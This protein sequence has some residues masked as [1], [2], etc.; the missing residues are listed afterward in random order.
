MTAQIKGFSEN[1]SRIST[2]ELLQQI[3]AALDRGETE[4]EVT[5]SGHHI[6]GGPF[7]SEDGT[8]LKFEVKN[9][10][11]RVGGFGLAGTTI[12]VDGPTPADAGWLN[13]GAELIIK[14]DSGDTTAHCAASGKIYVAGR[15]GTR[16]GSLMKHDPAF[17]APELWV[18]K[19]AGSFSFEFMGGGTAVICGIDCDDYP[20]LLGDRSRMGMVG[21]TIYVRGPVLNLPEEVWL[22]DLNEADRQFLSTGLP[23]FLDKVDHAQNLEFL[24]DFSQWKKITAKTYDERRKWHSM[25]PTMREFRLNKWVPDNGIFGGLLKDDYEHVAGLVTTGEDRLKI[26]HWKNKAFCAPCESACP[27]SIPTQDRINLLRQGKYK[28]AIELVL[29]YSP[30]PGSVCGEVCPN[31]CMDACTRQFIDLPVSMPEL[32]KLSLE[33]KSPEAKPDTGR[34]VA[35]IGGGPGGLSAAWHLRLQGHATTIFE[36]DQDVGGK[37]RQVIPSDRLPENSLNGEINRVKE[38]GVDI[39]TNS[40]V[41]KKIFEQIQQDFDAVIIASGAHIPVVIPFPGHERLVKGLDFL[42]DVNNGSKPSIGE[43]VVVIG[44][45]NAGMDVCLGAYAMGAKKVTAIDI[46]RPAA[47]KKEINHF[48]KL[49]GSIEWPVFTENV[50]EKGLHTKDGR[51]IEAD[52]VIISIGERP[53]LGY[54]PREWL[55]ERGMAAVDECGQLN[56]APGIFAIGD[57]IQPGLLTHAIGHGREAAGY[58]DTFLAG[59]ELVPNKKLPMI[60]Q[61]CLTKELFRPQVRSR[62]KI[63]DAKTET[64][65]CLSCGTCRDCSMCLEACPEG[66]IRRDEKENG[67]VEYISDDNYCIGCGI[68][69]AMCP[70]GIWGMEQAV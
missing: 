54:L 67:S 53:D 69:S 19:N 2:Q 10:G 12:V 48:E 15:V 37:L 23:V 41:D 32:G 59:K 55:D 42:K 46:Q 43:K 29:Q 49:G 4:F 65:R 63:D 51:L 7:W 26:P 13:A 66:A 1:N 11:Q 39:K 14:G 20:S 3:Y 31:P 52:T 21:G 33:A 30:F 6:I 22:L 70:C 25:R 27:S 5:A 44:A 58:I 40:P 9:P 47:F 68:C 18:M 34:S 17:P 64:N 38:I 24:T 8:P 28:E 16:S 57:T 56:A 60:A 35:V 62:F 45:G 36:A 50:S 61:E